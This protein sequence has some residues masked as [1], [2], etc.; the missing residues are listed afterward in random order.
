MKNTL[1]DKIQKIEEKKNSLEIKQRLLKEKEK[2][3]NEKLKKKKYQELGKIADKTGILELDEDLLF[4]AF[5]E[6][7][8]LSEYP[9]KLDEWKTSFKNLNKSIDE[10]VDS[11]ISV[12]FHDSIGIS[13]K[14]K[15]K[16]LGMRYNKFRNEFYGYGEVERFKI[17]LKKF[18]CT[19]EKIQS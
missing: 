15:M 19:I 7:K 13:E 10:T 12:K 4:G 1:K 16:E 2:K 17:E 14:T 6:I 8:K 5:I 18:Q 11:P 9:K 3:K